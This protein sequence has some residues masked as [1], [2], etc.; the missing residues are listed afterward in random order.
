M[1]DTASKDTLAPQVAAEAKPKDTT[2][3]DL[4]AKLAESTM[5]DLVIIMDCTGSM[6][7]YIHKAQQSVRE[8]VQTIVAAESADVRFALVSY[9]DHPPQDSS[10][11][12]KVYPF[13]ASVTKMRKNLDQLS[14]S[15]G[16]DGPEAVADGLHQATKL[17]YR[18]NA[19]K[20]VVLIADAPPHG[21]CGHMH[22]GFPN[23]C[24]DGLDPI[25]ICKSL[26]EMGIS[27]YC[28]GCEPA[29]TPYKDFFQG[30]AHITG[31]Q[32]APL[33]SA[34]GLSSL[35][36]GGAREEIAMERLQQEVEDELQAVAQE[37][38]EEEQAQRLYDLM[39]KRGKKATRLQKGGMDMAAPTAQSCMIAGS[40]SMAEV[41]A[42]F[43][44]SPSSGYGSR[45]SMAGSGRARAK[46]SMARG[47]PRAASAS[48]PLAAAPKA[49]GFSLG[50]LFGFGKSAP[51]P[52]PPTA[53]AADCLL[54]AEADGEV[55]AME[56]PAP[57]AVS[58]SYTTVS[59][60]VSMEQCRRMLKKSKA[61]SACK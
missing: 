34:S 11:V 12:T 22:D 27:L 4:T 52:A 57:G 30:L 23:G 47:G 53:M 26:A 17:D 40:K 32:Y 61:R 55:L 10:Y 16:G 51:A 54:E 19:T 37:G 25:H 28:V 58:N 1:S 9:R 21:L 18:P 46:K 35:I 44:A 56:A 43:K 50:G 13:T 29:I 7:S 2:T 8:M 60:S 33:S 5:L 6:G 38:T 14:A 31:G 42:A 24:P 36:V 48:A 41:K 3:G 20:I 59:E 15:G 45:S 49:A 39:A